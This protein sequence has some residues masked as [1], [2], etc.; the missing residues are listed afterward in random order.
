MQRKRPLSSNNDPIEFQVL[1]EIGIISQL[2]NNR[3]ARLLSPDLNMSQFIVLNHFSRMGDERS[4]VQ[5]ATAIQVTKGAMSNTIARLHDKGLVVVR[6]D[7]E[8]GRGKLVSITAAGRAMRNRAVS[9]LGRGL[10][11]I[12]DVIKLNELEPVL[13]S[14]RKL[15]CWF[16]ENR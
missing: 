7:P 15:R 5:L 11:S 10:S 16:D 8:D 6:A 13:H 4:L 1:N 3:A 9:K 14:L 2:A 12:Y